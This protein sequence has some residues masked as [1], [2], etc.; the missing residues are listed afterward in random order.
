MAL[1]RSG[2]LFLVFLLTGAAAYVAASRLGYLNQLQARIIARV[3]RGAVHLSPGDFP[4]GVA[5]PVGDIAAVPL[6]PTVIG[7]VPRGSS[8]ALLVAAGGATPAEAD[9][10]GPV[11]AGTFKNAYAIQVR[12]IVFSREE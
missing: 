11:F 9:L 7:F 8:A 3:V 2:W 6:R 10:P 5:A 12:A 4:A 1:K